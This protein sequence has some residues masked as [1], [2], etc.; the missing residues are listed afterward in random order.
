MEHV[1]RHPRQHT[2][3]RYGKVHAL[4]CGVLGFEVRAGAVLVNLARSQILL[5]CVCVSRP[6]FRVRFWSYGVGR[7]RAAG[8]QN[9][10]LKEKVRVRQSVADYLIGRSSLGA[11]SL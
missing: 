5:R 10:C 1:S 11:S 9:V 7:L 2:K 8:K 4:L 3:N 6:G